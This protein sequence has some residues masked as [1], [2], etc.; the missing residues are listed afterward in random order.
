MEPEGS[1]MGDRME[2]RIK[3]LDAN[4]REDEKVA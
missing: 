4:V 3:W 1:T 2:I